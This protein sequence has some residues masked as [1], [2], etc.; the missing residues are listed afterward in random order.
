EDPDRLET[1]QPRE[2]GFDA[3]DVA[4]EHLSHGGKIAG[5]IARLVEKIDEVQADH[6][7]TRI[8][9]LDAE[10]TEEML[11]QRGG[12][13]QPILDAGDIEPAAVAAAGRTDLAVAAEI[14][15]ALTLTPRALAP[16]L[17]VLAGELR[18]AGAERG[19]LARRGHRHVRLGLTVARERI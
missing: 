19:R 11:A 1:L 9:D 4:A 8:L 10:L 12:A 3:R 15:V 13:R 16:G 18:L 5:E 7:L 6:P 17:D 14:D 2:E